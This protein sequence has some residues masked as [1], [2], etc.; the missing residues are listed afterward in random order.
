MSR[1]H[2]YQ[3]EA[4]ETLRHTEMRVTA[5]HSTLGE[6]L[7]KIDPDTGLQED[8]GPGRV[9][10]VSADLRQTLSRGWV[11]ATLEKADARDLNTG[12]PTAEAP[13]TIVDLV[14]MLE[15]LPLRLNAKAEF[16]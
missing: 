10:F 6:Q 9:R 13:R 15:R 2:A 4:S 16:E 5:G 1:A 7:A 11:M 8:Q 14:G 12:Q 3:L